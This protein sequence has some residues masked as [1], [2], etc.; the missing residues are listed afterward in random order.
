MKE[1]KKLQLANTPTPLI[2]SQFRNCKFLIKRDDFTGVELSGNKVRK[3][4][5]LLHEAKRQKCNYIF[6]SGGDQS[7]HAR[8]T[9]IA[10]SS[11]GMKTKLFL[12]GRKTK[13][14][15]GNLFLDQ[16][17]NPEISFL[18]RKEYDVVPQIMESE[19]IKYEKKG[20]KV[21]VIPSGGSSALGIWG[22]INFINELSEQ[23]D[24]NKLDGITLAAGSAGTA[25]GILIGSTLLG[26]NLKIY[27]VNVV[28]SAEVMREKII[29]LAKQCIED[30]KIDVLPNYDNVK[31]LD[32]YSTEGYKNV[33]PEK[34]SL[35]K[36]FFRE[37]GILLDPTYTGKAFV[38]YYDHFLKNKKSTKVLFLHTGGLFGAFAKRKD[39][40]K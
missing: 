13:N 15:E 8:A 37:S 10:A 14:S 35:I 33:T 23:T 21:F 18:T 6:T 32:G 2:K 9:V 28:Y 3:L 1:P 30:F 22:Y 38:A 29:T 17:V 4:E 39:Y 36:D 26:V 12:W 16:I 40:L 7:N 27:A 31:I 19:K 5:Y 24:L 34:I 25:A 20:N 11:L